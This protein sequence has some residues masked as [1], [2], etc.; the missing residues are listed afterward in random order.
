MTRQ[1]KHLPV[2]ILFGVM[3]SFAF[4]TLKKEI[5]YEFNEGDSFQYSYSSDTKVV[6]TIMSQKQEIENSSVYVFDISVSEASSSSCTMEAVIS[7]FK[8]KSS[9][10]G[11]VSE[12]DSED[13]EK[14]GGQTGMIYK[15]LKGHKYTFKIDNNGNIS[16]LEGAEE[17]INKIV[18]SLE[19]L[20]PAQV[21]MLKNQLE[22]SMS[23]DQIADMFN[24][25]FITLKEGGASKGDTWSKTSEISVSSFSMKASKDFNYATTENSMAKVDIKGNMKTSEGASMNLMGMPAKINLSGQLQGEALLDSESVPQKAL[26]MQVAK[27]DVKITEPASGQLMVIP[28]ELTTQIK[29]QNLK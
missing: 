6:Q 9:A 3:I 19:N 2:L 24:Q 12:F 4:T 10:N 22:A 14:G 17:L 23:K 11:S 18:A 15:N 21:D 16:E 1:L 27:G 5:S 13:S 25:I 20:P 7:S 29:V 8:N 28:M 26:Y